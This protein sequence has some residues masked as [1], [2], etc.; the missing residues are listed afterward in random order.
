LL[1][2]E[3][4]QCVAADRTQRTHVGISHAVKQANRQADETP[5][6]SLMHAQAAGLAIAAQAR[7]DYEI[8]LACGDGG[9]D[10]RKV[11]RIVAA[12]VAH[13][14]DHWALRRSA[15]RAD[16]TGR[17]VSGT[18]LDHHV[19]A[20]FPCPRHR[21]VTT[22]AVDDNDLV[23]GITRNGAKDAADCLAFIE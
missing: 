13:E 7:A 19:S 15:A 5:G 6:E 20:G 14:W 22:A 21:L 18:R 9:D 12:I 2:A 17:A 1:H 11:G 23:D 4:V 16:E 3:R 8:L 10:G